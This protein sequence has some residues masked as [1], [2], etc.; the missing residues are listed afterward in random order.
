M[1]KHAVTLSLKDDEKVFALIVYYLDL[2]SI[3]WWSK[4]KTVKGNIR[5]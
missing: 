3:K 1:T 5:F 4:S 2:L